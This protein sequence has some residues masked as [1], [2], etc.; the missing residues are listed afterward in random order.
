MSATYDHGP[1]DDYEVTWLNGAVDR[2]K[3]HQVT[4]T[5]G[6]SFIDVGP[7][8]PRRVLFHGEFD[9]QWRLVFSA[10]EDDIRT[11]RNLTRCEET[12]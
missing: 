9:G 7:L 6:L 5:G 2:F 4:S 3:A 12:P 8:K 11:I 1:L 10:L